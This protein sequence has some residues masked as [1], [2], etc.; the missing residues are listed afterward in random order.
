MNTVKNIKG[1]ILRPI[2]D[3]T[4]DFKV[5]G[6]LLPKDEVSRNGVLYDWD[7]IKAKPETKDKI[8]NRKIELLQKQRLNYLKR[9]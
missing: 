8:I 7:S 9:Y 1:C 2:G 3:F 6:L 5:R 4:E